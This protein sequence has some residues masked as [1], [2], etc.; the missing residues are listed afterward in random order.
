VN[1]DHDVDRSAPV[2]AASEIAVA[3]PP[4][5]VW[6]VLA[7]IDQ[8]PSWNPDVK[9]ASL[10]GDVAEGTRFRWK[11]GPG[12]ITSILQRVERPRL[13]AWSGRTFGI[14]AVHVWRL[15]PGNAGTRVRTEESFHGVFARVFRR[16]LQKTLARTLDQGLRHLKAEAERRA[17]VL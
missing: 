7:A 15:E 13:I 9:W 5:T 12:T 10:E 16:W 1:D 3:A 8:W 2:V 17:V 14:D 11:S 6:E 4:D